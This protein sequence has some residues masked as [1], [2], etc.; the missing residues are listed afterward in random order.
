MAKKLRKTGTGSADVTVAPTGSGRL[1]FVDASD[2]IEVY[3]PSGVEGAD[4]IYVLSH[5]EPKAVGVTYTAAR[6]GD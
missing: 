2:A 5:R 3:R 6:H 1:V 4:T